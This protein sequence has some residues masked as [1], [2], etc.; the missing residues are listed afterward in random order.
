MRASKAFLPT[1]RQD[2]AEAELASHK[3]LLR[4]G[5]IRQLAAGVYSYLPL[6]W[7]VVQN[8]ADMVRSEMDASG[9]QELSLPALHPKELWERSGRYEK[10]ADTMHHVEDKAGR[11][12]VLGPTHEEVITDIVRAGV[13]SHRQLPLILYQ[14]QTKF[15]DEAR[16]RGGLV[17]A[18]EFIM[19]DA[20]S[21][22][23]DYDGLEESYRA[24]DRA[25]RRVFEKC[26]VSFAAV[27]AE[28]AAMG[29]TEAMEFMLPCEAGEDV[30]LSCGNCGYAANREKAQRLSP[31]MKDAPSISAAPLERVATPG[32]ATVAQVAEFLSVPA[33]KL[34]KTLIYEADGEPAAALVPG[35][36]ELNESKLAEALGAKS[37]EMAGADT[38]QRVTGAP[39][40]FAGPV[41]L[42]VPIAADFSLRGAVDMVTGANEADAHLVH[43]SLGRD[44][45]VDTWADLA[46]AVSGDACSKCGQPLEEHAA[47]EL[48]HIFK[49]GTF[50]SERLEAYYT[51][52]DGAKKPIVMGCYGLGV[53]RLAA[54]IAEQHRDRDGIVWP[55]PVAPWQAAVIVVNMSDEKQ[56]AL[57]EETYE[58]LLAAGVSALLDDRQ[59]PPGA[60]FKDIDLVGIPLQ[61][62]VGK[63]A[64]EGMVEIRRRGA[65]GSEYV[66]SEASA[67]WAKQTV[68]EG[69]G[70]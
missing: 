66:T 8:I 26:E 15:R 1:M 21:F 48:G 51:D 53:S 27:E 31:D 56:A 64:A 35:D 28:A 29:G 2:P 4:G 14:I 12:F 69:N 17:R 59:M 32:K 43:V 61:L 20:Y 24:M 34:I 3:L 68:G 58:R 30:F 18:R 16:P 70:L 42:K 13:S 62:V 54:A 33:S 25:Y 10:W 5:F 52:E 57:G 55:I 37:L 63:R 22:D 50:Y 40:G 36:R 60:K 65:A 7:R 47:I 39:V 44:F 6:G 23:R 19:K 49:L 38:I 41:G 11:K 67:L 9:A 46:Y 45:R